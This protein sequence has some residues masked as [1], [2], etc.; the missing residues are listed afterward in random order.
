MKNLNTPEITRTL[1]TINSEAISHSICRDAILLPSREG[2]EAEP[3]LLL[4]V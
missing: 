2:E 1:F 3:P 4:C